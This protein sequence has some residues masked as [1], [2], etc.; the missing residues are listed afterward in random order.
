MRILADYHHS[1]LMYAFHRA[2]EMKLGHTLLRPIGMEWFERGFFDVAKPYGNNPATV[3]QFLSMTEGYEPQDGSPP[4]NN[5]LQRDHRK[6]YYL[7]DEKYHGYVQR[8]ISFQQFIETDIDV[9]IASIPDHWY[10][11]KRLRD[12]FKPK[13]KLICHMGNM[14][15]EVIPALRDGTIENLMAS[16]LPLSLPV[17]KS[18]N[19]VHVLYYYQDQPV[20]EGFTPPRHNTINSYVHV[21]PMKEQYMRYKDALADTIDMKAYGGS[22]PDGWMSSLD[23]LYDSMLDSKMVYQVKPGGDGYGWNWHSA[24]MLGRAVITRYSDYQDKLGGLLFKDNVTGIDLDRGTFKENVARI[25]E[26]VTTEK[27]IEMGIEA[28]KRWKAHVDYEQETMRIKKF[29]ENLQ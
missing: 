22:C 8:A 1:G 4:L 14:F 28:Q 19:P 15:N 26:A 24:Y 12:Q 25:K 16:T 13:A 21:L 23:G 5:L 11:Y 29:L 6:S 9:I 3:R 2:F 17:S 27:H 10:T 18:G 7:V 20:I